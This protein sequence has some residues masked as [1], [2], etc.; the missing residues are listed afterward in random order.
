MVDMLCL[1]ARGRFY[2]NLP[3]RHGQKINR[4]DQEGKM[5]GIFPLTDI[6]YIFI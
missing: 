6:W 4:N 2:R 1:L 3:A 5:F